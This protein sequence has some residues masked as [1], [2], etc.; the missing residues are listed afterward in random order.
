MFTP[1]PLDGC[2]FKLK[3]ICHRLTNPGYLEFTRVNARA[4]FA[5]WLTS[6]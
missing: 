5:K 4:I 3:K 2:D 1:A 6:I